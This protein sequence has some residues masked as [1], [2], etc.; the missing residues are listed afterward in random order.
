MAYGIIRVEGIKKTGVAGIQIHDTR[1]K[2]VSHSNPDIKF[3]QSHLNY[4]L[5]ENQTNFAEAINTRISELDLKRAVRKDAN[6][7]AQL[8]ISASPDW[9]RNRTFDQ[10]KQ[11]FQDVY[12]W[13]CNRYGK[14]NIVSAIVHMDEATPHLHI[15]FVPITPDGRVSFEALFNERKRRDLSKLQDDFYE[16]NQSKGYDLERGERQT[17]SSK[18]EHLSVIDFKIQEDEKKL[19]RLD[20]KK[21]ELAD[22]EQ[23]LTK[24]NSEIKTVKAKHKAI[25]LPKKIEEL[26][27]NAGKS[28]TGHVK[29]VSY[30]DFIYLCNTLSDY[31]ETIFELQKNNNE[32]D[33]TIDRMKQ[34]MPRHMELLREVINTKNENSSL[35]KELDT[36]KEKISLFMEFINLILEL[37][38]EQWRNVVIDLQTKIFQTEKAQQKTREVSKDEHTLD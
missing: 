19:Q 20:E 2:G 16:H 36:V 7:M 9:M 17:D 27:E 22:V 5:H 25:L 3:E 34:Q 13:T 37:L 35:I 29:N 12:D 32:K 14:E 10:Q 38:P 30:D 31:Q 8:F 23:A 21:Q 4:D 18:R 15:N 11:F 33:T 28:F 26:R 1:E 6:I 24:K